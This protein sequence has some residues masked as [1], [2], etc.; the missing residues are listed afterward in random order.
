MWN[1]LSLCQIPKRKIKYF[2]YICLLYN[3]DGHQ[4]LKEFGVVP[5]PEGYF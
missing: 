1:I 2:W 4:T 3:L 5:N